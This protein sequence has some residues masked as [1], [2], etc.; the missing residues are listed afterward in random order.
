MSAFGG[1][2]DMVQCPLFLRKRT[3][4]AVIAMSALC[5]RR[6]LRTS[7]T[8]R[9][10]TCGNIGHANAKRRAMVLARAKTHAGNAGVSF[11][12][13]IGGQRPIR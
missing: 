3:F 5:Q 7:N 11:L 10:P 8:P 2:A 4:A 1:K 13:A 12:I 9:T 6:E